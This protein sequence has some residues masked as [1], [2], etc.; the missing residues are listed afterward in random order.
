[1]KGNE[2]ATGYGFSYK[3]QNP[4]YGRGSSSQYSHEAKEY[5][6][7]TKREHFAGLAMQGLA[8]NAAWAK[9]IKSNDWDDFLERISEGATEIADALIKALNETSPQ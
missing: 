7:L 8:A 1:M 9:T 4:S 3:R 5:S 2:P 6:G